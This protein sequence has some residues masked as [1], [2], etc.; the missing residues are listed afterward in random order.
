MVQF[1]KLEDSIIKYHTG[2]RVGDRGKDPTTPGD[3]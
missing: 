1:F 2:E 3:L